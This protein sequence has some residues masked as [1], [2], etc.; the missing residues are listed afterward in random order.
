MR[1][2]KELKVKVIL[3]ENASER[4]TEALLML[5]EKHKDKLIS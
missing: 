1:K 3:S 5:Y 4:L 2:R